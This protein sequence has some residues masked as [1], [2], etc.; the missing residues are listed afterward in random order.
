[1]TRQIINEGLDYKDLVGQLEPELSI[2]EYVAKMGDDA[3][4]IT[5]AFIVNSEAAGN[6]LVEWFERGYSFI[7]DAS[8]SEGE[9][10]I[11][12]YVVFV[13]MNRRSNAPERIIELLEDLET[14]TD[15]SLDD[16]TIE[17]D[18]EEYSAD[19][20][21]LKR[22]MVLSPHDYREVNGEDV[23]DETEDEAEPEEPE[24]PVE[25]P[26][27]EPAAVAAPAPT[28]P[29]PAMPAVPGEEAAMN[30]MRVAAGLPPKK[31]F[32]SQD[33]EIKAFKSMAGL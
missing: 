2:D 23:E 16:W 26:A 17:V 18:E 6:D 31:L 12:K 9:I 4:V 7:L 20:A 29:A 3:H 30:E 5:L 1:M 27:A 28:A 15:F 8:L 11:G 25:T 13:E 32:S 19:E 24:E 33:S 14:L 22:V 10:A 21:T